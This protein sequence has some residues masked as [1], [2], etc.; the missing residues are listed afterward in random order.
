MMQIFILL[1][2]LL[3]LLQLSEQYDECGL[4]VMVVSRANLLIFN[5]YSPK[6]R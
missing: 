5:N 1:L 2:L 6:W 4:L 3:L